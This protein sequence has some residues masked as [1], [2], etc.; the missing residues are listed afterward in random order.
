VLL[1]LRLSLASSGIR[2]QH[3]DGRQG[4]PLSGHELSRL[5][6]AVGSLE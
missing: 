6:L 2:R 1:R 4:F 5:L 3:E